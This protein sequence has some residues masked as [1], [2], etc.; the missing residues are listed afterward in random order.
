MGKVFFVIMVVKWLS[1]KALMGS[2]VSL[3]LIGS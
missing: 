1:D 3:L 2:I